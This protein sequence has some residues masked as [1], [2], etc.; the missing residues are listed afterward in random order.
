MTSHTLLSALKSNKPAFG[1]WI[2]TTS[3]IYARSLAKASPNLSWVML[4]CEHGLIS[5]NPGA[6]ELISAVN[7]IGPN[8]PSTLVRIPATGMS[9]GVNW[10][11][12]Y[13]LDAGA[14]GILVPM[15]GTV[16]KAR[17]IAADSRFAPIGRRGFGSAHTQEN[18]GISTMD[19]LKNANDNVVVMIQIET[20]EGVEN[21]EGIVA[22]EGIDGVFIGPY[23]LS[24]ALGYP[25]PNPDPHPEIEKIIQ[26][27]LQVTQSA[28]KKCAM[29]CTSGVQA[30]KRAKEGFD[31][32][33]VT[34]DIGALT[35]GIL[36]ELNAATSGQ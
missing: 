5:L 3:Q 33:N 9:T 36:S 21:M 4:D 15:V 19:Y 14:R 10:Q 28:G 22:V 7:S 24:I 26:R 1:A 32:I 16:E 20:K 23:D 13:A 17:E 30:A 18:W 35:T 29:Y 2:T 25:P 27:I 31:M 34:H 8:A 6:Y 11:I 12:K